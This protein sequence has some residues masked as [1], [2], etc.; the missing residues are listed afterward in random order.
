MSNFELSDLSELTFR[1]IGSDVSISVVDAT[2]EQ[3]DT[4]IR[5]QVSGLRNVSSD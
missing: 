1:P 4:Y 5:Q 2:P 3:F